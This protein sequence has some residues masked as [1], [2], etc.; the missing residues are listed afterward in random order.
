MSTLDEEQS[1]PLRLA[2]DLDDQPL[3]SLTQE[4]KQ[5]KLATYA[6]LNFATQTK[7]ATAGALLQKIREFSSRVGRET[8]FFELE[9]NQVEEKTAKYRSEYQGKTYFFCAEMCKNAFDKEPQ[10]YAKHPHG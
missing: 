9:W 6:Y 2:L 3:P 5:G 8:V 7:D 1:F 10:K 4:A